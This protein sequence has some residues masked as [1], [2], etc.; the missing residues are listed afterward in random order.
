MYVDMV[1]A[2]TVDNVVLTTLEDRVGLNAFSAGTSAFYAT[3][4]NLARVVKDTNQT[5]Y[6][7]LAMV[8]APLGLSG[9]SG[10]GLMA[11]SVNK[12][13]KYPNASL[14][15][16]QFF[17]NPRSMVQFS[18]TVA[19]YP[20]SASAYDDPFFASPPTA[21]EDSGRKLAKDIVATYQ[22]IVPTVVNKPDVNAIVRR[23]IESALFN[24]VPA[25]QALDQAVADANKIIK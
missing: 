6:D 11:I 1:K 18:K 4:P 5:L 23:A 10:K 24:N 20:S 7:N 3:G 22:D 13:T 17:T 2:G 8:Q 19:I 21:I 15:L 12:S 14:A 9:V 25:Q 16:A